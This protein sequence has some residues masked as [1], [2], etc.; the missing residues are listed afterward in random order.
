[1]SIQNKTHLEAINT[2]KELSESVFVF[3]GARLEELPID[4][5]PMSLKECDE[6][7]NLWLIS[8]VDSHKNID[9]S[10]DSRVQLFFMNNSEFQYLSVFG[11]AT[12]Y[13][14]RRTI[15]EKWTI[16]ANAWFTGKDDPN[17]SIIRVKPDGV[18]YWDTKAGKLV[19]LFTIA[20]AIISDDKSGDNAGVEGKLEI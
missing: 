15:E 14:D 12:I 16:M 9:I 3:F 18:S 11:R 13:Q 1:M 2:L 20:K 8:G 7:G 6:S 19:T 4:V 5:R 10:E 17:A